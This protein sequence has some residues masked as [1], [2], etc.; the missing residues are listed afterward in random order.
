MV[1]ITI[2]YTVY[3]HKSGD[4]HQR[5]KGGHARIGRQV[6]HPI[7]E[8]TG[9]G[10]KICYHNIHRDIEYLVGSDDSVKKLVFGVDVGQVG[11]LGVLLR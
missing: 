6:D 11:T 5:H 7:R 2:G 10:K 4:Q 9:E 1:E 3:K 8:T